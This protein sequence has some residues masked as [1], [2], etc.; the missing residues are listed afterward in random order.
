MAK[1]ESFHLLMT[2]PLWQSVVKHPPLLAAEVSPRRASARGGK[3][4]R[5]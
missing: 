5:K 1:Y 2:A 3:V 4:E